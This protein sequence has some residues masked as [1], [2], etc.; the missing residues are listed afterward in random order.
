MHQFFKYD[1]CHN[2]KISGDAPV[3]EGIEISRI[4]KTAD[5][6]LKPQDA[7]F[8]GR[9]CVVNIK[10]LP[11]GKGIGLLN[12][13]VVLHILPA[14]APQC[15]GRDVPHSHKENT[16]GFSFTEQALQHLNLL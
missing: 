15:Q 12:H 14:F 9:A 1:F 8:S 2:K 13:G 4:G 6:T 7:R 5:I 16:M 10:R 11:S 3:I